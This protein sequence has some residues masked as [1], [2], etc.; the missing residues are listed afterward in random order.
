MREAGP[1]RARFASPQPTP[2]E[3]KIPVQFL[4]SPW[5]GRR[6]RKSQAS[7]TADL[8]RQV[9]KWDILSET[10]YGRSL[11]CRMPGTCGCA[12]PLN[13]R[14]GLSNTA[15]WARSC[16][17]RS[18]SSYCRSQTDGPRGSRWQKDLCFRPGVQPWLE[19]E[20]LCHR[21]HWH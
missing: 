21:R 1:S 19:P 10:D 17:A 16:P 5:G 2:L 13:R 9:P 18:W 6:H 3:L 12:A 14:S 8:Q 7:T 11:D 15:T 20:K 4:C